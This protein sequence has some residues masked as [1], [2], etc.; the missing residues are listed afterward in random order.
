MTT[1]SA[2]GTS[3]KTGD[4]TSLTVCKL[5]RDDRKLFTALKLTASFN[6]VY[7]NISQRIKCLSLRPRHFRWRIKSHKADYRAKSHIHQEAKEQ[8][9]IR[10]LLHWMECAASL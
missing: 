7:E 8:V 9:D 5:S 2:V 4:V 6:S 1:T 10:H 3:S